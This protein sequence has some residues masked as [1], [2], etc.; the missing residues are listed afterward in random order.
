MSFDSVRDYEQTVRVL[1]YQKWLDEG[2]PHGRDV[3]HWVEA[4]AEVRSQVDGLLNNSGRR[5]GSR[6][7]AAKVSARNK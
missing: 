4:E 5:Q 1:A 3:E 6:K 2:C 7:V